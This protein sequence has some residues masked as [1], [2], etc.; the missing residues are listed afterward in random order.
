MSYEWME[1][2]QAMT[3]AEKL[4]TLN[5][6]IQWAKDRGKTEFLDMMKR[7]RDHL[8]KQMDLPLAAIRPDGLGEYISD[9]PG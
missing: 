6:A 1:K 7:T 2:L 3:P 4:R 5:D 9:Q 8:L